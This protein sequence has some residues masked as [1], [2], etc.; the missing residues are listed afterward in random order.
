[1]N[2]FCKVMDRIARVLGILR[3]V[4]VIFQMLRG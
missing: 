4:V 2:R 3:D 1:M